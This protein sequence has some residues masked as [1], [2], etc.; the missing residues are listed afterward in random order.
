MIKLNY[1][2]NDNKQQPRGTS[3]TSSYLLED[4]NEFPVLLSVD[5]SEINVLEIA[6]L[7][8]SASAHLKKSVRYVTLTSQA[9]DRNAHL[10][11][12]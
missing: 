8:L 3:R 10:S 1:F 12:S 11:M 2:H 5:L 6:L 9:L 4:A 7:L